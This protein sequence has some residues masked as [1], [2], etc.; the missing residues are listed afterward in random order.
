MNSSGIKRGLAATA[1]S[2]LAVT[3]I[4]LLATPAHADSNADHVGAGNVD[5]YTPIDGWSSSVQN[6]GNN[7]TIHLLAGGGPDVAQVRFEWSPAGANTWKQIATV[8]RA[9]GSFTTEW[10]PPNSSLGALNDVRATGLSS[11]GTPIAGA[12]RTTRVTANVGAVDIANAPG[13]ALG[14]F[15]QPYALEGETGVLGIVS[16]TTSS[17]DLATLWEDQTGVGTTV[18]PGAANGAGIRS[19]RGAVRFD[20]YQLDTVAPLVDEAIVLVG[21]DEFDA[22]VVNLE[23]QKVSS[24][25]AVAAPASVPN[26]TTSTGVVSAADAAGRPIAGAQVFADANKNDV[27]DGAE[28]MV[29]TDENGEARFPGLV[30]SVAGTEYSYIVNTTDGDDY[31]SSVDFKR[32]ITVTSFAQVPTT[33]T[34]TSHDGAAFDVDEADLNDLEVTVVDQNAVG[35]PGQTVHYTL[36]AALFDATLPTPAPQRGSVVTGVGGKAGVPFTDLGSGTYTLKTFIE[37]NGTPGQQAGDLSGADLGFKAGDSEL[38]FAD[39]PEAKAIAGTTETLDA[40]LALSDGTALPG[41]SVLFTYTRT[42]N[43]VAAAQGNQPAGTTR[44]SDTQATG[45]TGAD[46]TASV[47]LSDPAVPDRAELGGKLAADTAANRFG[48]AVEAPGDLDVNFYDA[49]PPPR[50]TI[51]VAPIADGKPGTATP[52]TVTV[53]S[54][55]DNDPA[56]PDVPVEGLAVTLTVGQDAFFTNETPPPGAVLGADAELEDLG[57]SLPVYTDMN[58]EAPFSTSIGRDQGFDDNG[59]VTAA[60]TATSGGVTGSKNQ[61][62]DS[63]DPVNGGEVT[64]SISPDS[65]QDNPV[66]PTMSG[67]FVQYDV[68]ATDQFGNVVGGEQV[69]LT[70]DSN[71]AFGSVDAT[72]DF[73]PDG[74]FVVSTSEA[75]TV[76]VTATWTTDTTLYG[77]DGLDPGTELDPVFTADGE[78]VVGTADADFYEVDFTASTFS[79]TSNP[80]GEVPVGTAVTETAKVVDQEGN[81]VQGLV[82]EFIRSGPGNQDGDA[83]QTRDTNRNGEAFYSFTGTEAGT[84]RISAVITDGVHNKTLAHSV[85]FASATPPRPP[86]KS[87]V[88]AEL[89]G[90][91]NGGKADR[92]RVRTSPAAERARVRLFSRVPGHKKVLVKT[93]RLNSAGATR[94]WARD[95]NGRRI[96]KYFVKVSTTATTKRDRSTT[97]RLR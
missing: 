38:A 96:T 43:V 89:L 30:G 64:L 48:N 21:Q 77:P 40:T 37:Q 9:N 50:S 71:D 97:R 42:G 95:T 74:D 6:D 3:G 60:V 45:T 10:A 20:G 46:G 54:D 92:L 61:K 65:E 25:G 53:T 66:D 22:E 75:E 72:S 36:S 68:T 44:H 73:A 76:E 16:G 4:P 80:E 5:F 39:A 17:A 28:T 84:A 32:T 67:N 63:S 8:D 82:V 78:D 24:V 31:Q 29:Y 69:D 56:T 35:M 15:T 18:T 12:L 11:V 81:P 7:T 1:I 85:T 14:T 55:H 2:A 93:K 91:N 34:S 94:F 26:G 79:L 59:L 41:R 70:Y 49:T 58:G 86:G 83:N 88:I 23:A 57:Q 19:F 47:A 13:S 51:T 62:F 87:K 90:K 33:V 27:F 52:G